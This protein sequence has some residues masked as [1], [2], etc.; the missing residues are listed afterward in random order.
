MFLFF[1]EREQARK[2]QKRSKIL[3]KEG[4]NSKIVI[5]DNNAFKEDLCHL[6]MIDNE[7]PC[8]CC[9]NTS[10]VNIHYPLRMIAIRLK[11]N[12]KIPIHSYFIGN[13]IE[14]KGGIRNKN[15]N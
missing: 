5:K 6:E 3:S 13:Q 10:N 12:S 9:S 2:N 11:V 1:Q 7:F 8:S 15:E 4:G 14:L